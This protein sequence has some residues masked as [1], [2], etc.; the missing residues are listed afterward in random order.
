MLF[1]KGG[2]HQLLAAESRMN[3]DTTEPSQACKMGVSSV[4]I[5]TLKRRPAK[6]AGLTERCSNSIK[7]WS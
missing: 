7:R 2:D 5:S 6:N 3:F 4:E 1:D